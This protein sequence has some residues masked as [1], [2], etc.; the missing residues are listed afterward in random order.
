MELSIIQS[1]ICE[2]RGYNVILDQ[3]L[4]RMY[5]VKNSEFIKNM[6]FSCFIMK[7]SVHL[8]IKK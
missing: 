8:G 5:N 7:N 1:N 3:D 6:S 4:A 2:I